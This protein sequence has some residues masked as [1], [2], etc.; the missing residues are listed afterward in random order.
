MG[1]MNTLTKI[2]S[3]Q[4][5]SHG[6]LTFPVSIEMLSKN[7]SHSTSWN[8]FCFTWNTQNS[9]PCS[10]IFLYASISF[11]TSIKE[12]KVP[13]DIVT[14]VIYIQQDPK[15]RKD[16]SNSQY[17]FICADIFLQLSSDF[18][19]TTRIQNSVQW[20]LCCSQCMPDWDLSPVPCP[21]EL[22]AHFYRN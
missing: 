22:L 17:V 19:D 5:D 4:R 16:K 6:I 21:L 3:Q 20:L 10:P 7:T 11:I 9:S 12:A 18:R 15:V 8:S 13:S 2:I 1:Y 14:I